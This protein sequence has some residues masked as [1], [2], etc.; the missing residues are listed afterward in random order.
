[1]KHA[2]INTHANAQDADDGAVRSDELHGAGG[3]GAVYQQIGFAPHVQADSGSISDD[4][5]READVPTPRLGDSGSAHG[6]GS[7]VPNAHAIDSPSH[8]SRSASQVSSRG[9]ATT[10]NVTPTELPLGELDGGLGSQGLGDSPMIGL[11]EGG[12]GM[13]LRPSFESPLQGAQR[14]ESG[15][16]GQEFGTGD[17]HIVRQLS[18]DS[19]AETDVPERR[20]SLAHHRRA[21][22]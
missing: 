22:T 16:L 4:G 14:A 15:T 18:S 2:G 10:I 13:Q 20:H 12:G 17:D 7:P 1:M 5:T 3:G 8:Q 21:H 9:G 11:T 19:D 6:A